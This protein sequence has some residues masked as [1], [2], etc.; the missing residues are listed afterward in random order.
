MLLTSISTSPEL[1]TLDLRIRSE[2]EETIHSSHGLP[3]TANT[4]MPSELLLQK[5]RREH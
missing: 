4:G 2:F 1:T 5:Q 3:V